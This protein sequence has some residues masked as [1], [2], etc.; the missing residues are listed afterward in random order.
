MHDDT[1]LFF[2]P[3]GA[4]RAAQLF[5]RGQ[6]QDVWHVNVKTVRQRGEIKGHKVMIRT[7]DNRNFP[8]TN[9]DFERLH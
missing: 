6:P 9:S 7:K 8:L 4:Q 5:L 1:A 3:E 2:T